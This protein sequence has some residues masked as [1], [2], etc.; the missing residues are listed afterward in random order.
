MQ[1]LQRILRSGNIHVMLSGVKLRR[2]K[3][4]EVEARRKDQKNQHRTQCEMLRLRPCR[5]PL[6]MT[7]LYLLKTPATKMKNW[8]HSALLQNG[9]WR[10]KSMMMFCSSQGITTWD[11]RLHRSLNA[12]RG[13]LS[14][15]HTIFDQRK[16][17]KSSA[18][19]LRRTHRMHPGQFV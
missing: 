10:K 19:F 7:Y 17:Q 13:N 1:D 15:P 14:L 6:S 3:R 12:S 9:S 18:L 8:E 11:F 16:R 5:A 4:N 2:A